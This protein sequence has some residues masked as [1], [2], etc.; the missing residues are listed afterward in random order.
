MKIIYLI[1]FISVFIFACN[2]NKQTEELTDESN[3]KDNDIEIIEDSVIIKDSSD[4]NIEIETDTVPVDEYYNDPLVVSY[5]KISDTMLISEDCVLFLWPDSLEVIEMQ[6]KYPDGYMEILDDMI[7]YASDAAIALD[8]ADIR[9]FFCDKSV[10]QFVSTPK[11]IFIKRKKTDG[12]M[13][14]LKNGKEPY[15]GY[16][17][18]FNLDSCLIYFYDA[19]I[20]TSKNY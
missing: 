5:T 18:D 11:D 17:I 16:T 13:I 19:I 7:Y 1:L 14:F 20:D 8:G 10:I 3:Q 2:G 9:N 15:I 12:N 4:N 6:N